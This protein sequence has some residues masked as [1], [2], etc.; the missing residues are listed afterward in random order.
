MVR[1]LPTP[2]IFEMEVPCI[3][4]TDGTILR[5]DDS[6]SASEN[7]VQ[8]SNYKIG[9][10]NIGSISELEELYL[11]HNSEQIFEFK[12]RFVQRELNQ[13]LSQ[14]SE[15]NSALNENRILS[16]IIEELIP[17]VREDPGY[18]I[19][20]NSPDLSQQI[21]D[22][23]I[24]ESNTENLS[25]DPL[26]RS[27]RRNSSFQ[28]R[29][30]ENI[31]IMDK[32]VWKLREQPT[33][34]FLV[35]LEDKYLYPTFMENLDNLNRRYMKH[36]ET[37]LK[38]EALQEDVYASDQLLR[39]KNERD[40]LKRLLQQDGYCKKG[41]GFRKVRGREYDFY[42][43]TGNYALMSECGNI[44]NMGNAEIGVTLSVI[45]DRIEVSDPKILNR[46]KHPGLVGYSTRQS[47][48]MG[49]YPYRKLR[50]ELE[51]KDLVLQFIFDCKKK[52]MLTYVGRFGW[53]NGLEEG[54]YTNRKISRRRANSLG[55]P[56]TNLAV[57]ERRRENERYF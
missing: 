49:S 23:S 33:S 42:I 43:E 16:F 9:L 10:K 14:N 19:N 56:I 57:I 26:I 45:N 25:T 34:S 55:I 40:G 37:E 4:S 46:Y 21:E 53:Q 39:I 51:P 30:L 18:K 24:H 32:R 5:L 54:S 13:V 52:V 6:V 22:V 3:F 35:K 20:D 50:E 7:Y 28:P 29:D 1:G 11:D 2:Y 8:T 44:M 47:F 41:V 17:A 48:C 27:I 38:V 36:L 31:L 12:K 15:L